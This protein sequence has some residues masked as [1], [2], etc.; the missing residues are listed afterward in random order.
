M[1]KGKID[2][3][4]CWLKPLPVTMRERSAGYHSAACRGRV[5]LYRSQ[6]RTIPAAHAAIQYDCPRAMPMNN[7]T[8]ESPQRD[9]PHVDLLL[10][11][12]ASFRMLVEA[13]DGYA[14]LMLDMSG[15]V[16]SWNAG[17]QKMKGYRADEIIGRHFSVFHTPED[18]AA[19]NPATQLAKAAANE[20]SESEGWRLRKDGSKFWANVV[21]TAIR[22]QA[23]TLIGFG[24]VTRDMT[25]RKRLADLEHI[26]LMS[27]SIE[28]AREEEQVRIARELHDDLGQQLT[29][30][31]M[32]LVNTE[33]D[34]GPDQHSEPRRNPYTKDMLDLLDRTMDSVRRIASGLRPIPLDTLGLQPALAWFI[35]D[36]TKRHGI[37]VLARIEIGNMDL[38]E[39][40]Q[41]SLFR[42]VQEALTNVAKH[43][44]ATQVSV[45]LARAGKTCVVHIEDNGQ[46]LAT[47]TTPSPTSFGLLG[48][49]ERVHRLNGTISVGNAP[50]SGLRISIALPLW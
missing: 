44:F 33:R 40:A 37:D 34:L 36:F 14:I 41:T 25:E 30:L 12:D 7:Q 18:Q 21:I 10:A 35:E 50:G 45:E 27:A 13:I 29:A 3:N 24:K 20:T 16:V 38:G 15:V 2:S 19:L 48:M 42:I 32:A 49:R 5:S 26:S 47:G 6:C 46:G 11:T 8:K 23:G 39:P 31:K 17:A 9:R 43:S 1:R 28:A 4:Q 22:D